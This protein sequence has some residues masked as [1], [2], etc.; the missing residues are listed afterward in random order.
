MASASGVS[1]ATDTALR[2]SRRACSAGSR[3]RNLVALMAWSAP[4]H[5]KAAMTA[6]RTTVT[7]PPPILLATGGARTRTNRLRAITRPAQA[8]VMVDAVGR[9]VTFQITARSIRPP[10]SGR[11]GSRLKTPTTR[12][13]T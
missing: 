3:S 9:P 4:V 11:P 2:A 7:M 12:W 13:P 6:S 10:S 1:A 5:M 8:A